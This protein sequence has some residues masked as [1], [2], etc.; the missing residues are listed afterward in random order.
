MGNQKKTSRNLIISRGTRRRVRRQRTTQSMP[1]TR[2]N[3][4]KASRGIRNDRLEPR[5]KGTEPKTGS[6]SPGR[7]P[8]SLCQQ[9]SVPVTLK[10][11]CV[12]SPKHRTVSKIEIMETPDVMDFT[13]T[14]ARQETQI[15]TRPSEPMESHESGDLGFDIR[16]LENILRLSSDTLESW[17]RIL[18]D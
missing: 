14:R 12:V 17:R 6:S 3:V 10:L 9:H 18:M 11:A 5:P 13:K 15:H 4:K 2:S 8:K 16:S 1:V 7:E